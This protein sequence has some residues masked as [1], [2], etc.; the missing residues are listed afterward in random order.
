MSGSDKSTRN[1]DDAPNRRVIIFFFFPKGTTVESGSWPCPKAKESLEK[2][3]AAFW[4]DGEDRRKNRAALRRYKD[5]RDTMAC[6]FYDRFARR[7]PCEDAPPRVDGRPVYFTPLVDGVPV[8]RA[9]DASANAT[10]QLNK[11][12]IVRIVEERYQGN[13]YFVRFERVIPADSPSYYR[14][15]KQPKS[16]WICVTRDGEQFAFWSSV[17][18][19]ALS[20]QL[21]T[22]DLD[23][24][25]AALS[26]DV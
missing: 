3:K 8:L 20:R 11:G 12:D 4:S 5:T 24:R 23:D 26:A 14:A 1:A 16:Q 19:V 7:S 6:R 21:E 10:A 9:P 13:A 22:N 15:A 25:F 2:C 17:D 18:G